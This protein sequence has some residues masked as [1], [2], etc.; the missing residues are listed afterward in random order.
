MIWPWALVAAAL[1]AA[2][3]YW[4]LVSTEGTYLGPRAVA[5]LYDRTATRYDAI[6]QIRHVDEQVYIGLPL[7][8]RL[9][10]YERPL[11]L[12]VATGTARVPLALMESSAFGGRAFGGDRSLG[13]LGEAA[14]ATASW[15]QVELLRFDADALPFVDAA[16]EAV[17]CLEA[18]EFFAD[19]RR[20]LAEFWRVLK[21]GGL[22]LL[23]NRVGPEAALFPGRISRRGR[24]EEVLRGMGYTHVA[25]QRWQVHYDL[26]WAE[27]PM[28]RAGATETRRH[29]EQRT[30][31]R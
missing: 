5:L 17:S 2:L 24:L 10:V 13:M 18:L 1:V 4:L 15:P 3:V 9:S 30:C 6:K 20:A 12:D 16:F 23:S 29:P 11:V 19:G 27:R 21:P 25:T 28:G 7:T 14:R 26:V 8:E 22:V 31:T